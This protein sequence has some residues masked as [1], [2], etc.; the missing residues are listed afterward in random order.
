MGVV[1]DIVAGVVGVGGLLF[2][3]TERQRTEKHERTL[4]DL[5]A[6]RDVIEDGAVELHRVAYVLDDLRGPRTKTLD[7]VRTELSDFGKHFDEVSERL[8]VRLGPDHDVT[9]AFVGAANATLEIFRAVGMIRDEPPAEEP[10]VRRQVRQYK[11]DQRDRIDA[12]RERFDQHRNEF[13]QAAAHLAA[14]KV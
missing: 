5:G 11:Q 6:A 2:G 12:E 10:H 9:R 8:K 13:I 3:W 1:S 14:V 4:T 7:V